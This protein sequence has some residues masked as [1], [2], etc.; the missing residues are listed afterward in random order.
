M[1]TLL[2]KS[3]LESERFG[4]NVYR[5]TEDND[6]DFRWVKSDIITNKIDLAI[7][8]LNSEKKRENNKIWNIGFPVLHADTLVYYNCKLENLHIPELKNDL[9]FERC[10]IDN[11]VTLDF[12]VREIF[13]NYSNHYWTNQMI[14]RDKALNGYVEWA[15]GFIQHNID[16]S[17]KMGWLVI[18]DEK[19]IGFATCSIEG[20]EGEGV[21]YG[22]LP[23]H[24]G[25]G[26]YTDM[27]RFTQNEMRKQGCEFM[28][29]S[30]QIHNFSVQKV[31]SREGFHLWKSYD[32][33][34]VNS[35][36]NFKIGIEFSEKFSISEKDIENIVEISGDD[37]EIHTN[38][39]FA[40]K[41]GLDGK[42]SHGVFIQLMQSRYFGTVFPGNG[43]LF[44]YMNTLFIKPLYLNKEYTLEFR[45][46]QVNGSFHVF[47][48]LVYDV[49]SNIAAVGYNGLVNKLL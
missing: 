32:T 29:V 1:I 27:I 20:T 30:T 2:K 39:A 5:Y 33:Y 7:I 37:N 17:N 47:N 4:M 19:Y 3:H 26:V 42:I 43:T 49:D 10:T 31:W 44:S 28:K 25:G 8:R 14:D 6:I 34:H 11:A 16:E 24:S 45:L 18:K 22:V 9:T 46:I 48:T 35:M 38:E 13:K 21:L 40:Q 23:E 36:L 41:I 12:L 15:C